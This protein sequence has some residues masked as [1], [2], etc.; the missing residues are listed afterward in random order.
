[1]RKNNRTKKG[2]KT[3]KIKGVYVRFEVVGRNVERF[4]A[5]LTRQGV[6]LFKIKRR[7][8]GKIIFS[9]KSEDER[10]FFAIVDKVWYNTFKIRK[11][12]YVGPGYPFYFMLKNFGLAVGIAVF[13]S[14]AA[15]SNDFVFSFEFTGSGSVY[16]RAIT[17]T[18]NENGVTRLSR[19]SSID[20]GSLEDILLKANDDLTFV[21]VKKV[22]NRLVI[23]SVAAIKKTER[24]T[25]DVASL[26]STEDGVIASLKVYRGTAV[27][28]V[29]DS[30][31]KGEVIVDGY[32]LVKEEKVSI[33]VIATVTI[34]YFE[35]YEIS[36]EDEKAAFLFAEEAS[37]K[38]SYRNEITKKE[39]AERSYLVKLYFYRVI[40]AG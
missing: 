13:I 2:V 36:A 1:M 20:F 40:T 29:G 24:L 8:T 32:A 25:G 19:F 18:L 30:V 16:E 5:S 10:K 3:E 4:T 27:K 38:T 6:A 34:S 14:L 23:D 11:L 33:N 17:R 28:A 22:G 15:I 39:N 31:K 21:S 7:G 37:G 26:V 12:R 35:E 9:L